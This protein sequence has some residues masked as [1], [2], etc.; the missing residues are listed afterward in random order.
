MTS[1]DAAIMRVCVVCVTL[2]NRGH[3]VV[4]NFNAR[5]VPVLAQCA[6]AAANGRLKGGKPIVILSD[7][8]KVSV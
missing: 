8:P 1:S 6:S 3:T 2:L 5:A 4:L 7:M